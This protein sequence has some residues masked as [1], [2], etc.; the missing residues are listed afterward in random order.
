[1]TP[2]SPALLTRHTVVLA[3]YHDL[4]DV[5]LV[6]MYGVSPEIAQ[7]LAHTYG[8]CAFA[9]CELARPTGKRWPRFGKVRGATARAGRAARGPRDRAG[10]GGRPDAMMV[11]VVGATDRRAGCRWWSPSN[12]VGL[13]AA[14]VYAR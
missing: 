13:R 6:Q 3:R 12:S 5:Q 9:V 10:G 7:H 1:M 14:V 11:V 8:A 4:L 2:P